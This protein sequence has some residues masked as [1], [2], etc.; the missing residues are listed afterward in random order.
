MLKFD[1][2]PNSANTLEASLVLVNFNT[3]SFEIT[4]LYISSSF[5]VAFVT[6]NVIFLHLNYRIINK[7]YRTNLAGNFLKGRFPHFLI[8]AGDCQPSRL[9]YF[10][11]VRE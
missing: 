8:L 6:I 4:H 9:L 7:I 1:V 2:S 11:L 10:L 5:T 3:N